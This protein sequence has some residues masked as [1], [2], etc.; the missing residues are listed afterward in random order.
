M[1]AKTAID[2]VYA[3]GV[4]LVKNDPPRAKELLTKA[5]QQLE[6]AA[7]AGIPASA[8]DPLRATGPDRSRRALQDGLGRRDDAVLVRR[9]PTRRSTCKG[10]VLGPDKAPY[11]LDGATHAVYRVDLKGGKAAP[12]VRAGQSVGGVKVA[13]PRFIALAGPD[14]LILDAKN[15]LWRWRPGR[16]DRQGDPGQGQGQGVGELGRRHP[17]DRCVRPQ[18][19]PGPLQPVRRR[20]VGRSRS[21]PTRRPST[22]RGFPGDPTRLAGRTPGR[23]DRGVDGHRRRHLP[24]PVGHDQPLRPRRQHRLE[25]GRPGRRPAPAGPGLLADRDAAPTRARA[26][27]YGYDRANRRV[28]GLAK[29]GGSVQGQYRLASDDAPAGA[30][31]AGCTSWPGP[32]TEPDTLVWI[33]KNRLMSSLL[34]ASRRRRPHPSPSAGASPSAEAHPEGDEEAEEDAQA[35]TP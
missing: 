13:E 5:W 29:D 28:L 18:R 8:I 19:R 20:P 12:V 3:P 32:D 22:A 26:R 34:E 27:V 17:G 35:V 31:C 21:W 2:E 30:T 9:L 11:V 4:N 24:V 7:A 23:R 15:A 10:V 16:Q 6:A 1:Q 33:D 14:L 25:A